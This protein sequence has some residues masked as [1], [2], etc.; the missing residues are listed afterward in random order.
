MDVRPY[1]RPCPVLT[2][3]SIGRAFSRVSQKIPSPTPFPKQSCRTFLGPVSPRATSALVDYGKGVD[4][5]G[6]KAKTHANPLLLLRNL[7]S[8]LFVWE[9][10][11]EVSFAPPQD[12]TKIICVKRR[13]FGPFPCL[14]FPFTPSSISLHFLCQG[15]VQSF[16]APPSPSSLPFFPLLSNFMHTNQPP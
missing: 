2:L 1:F 16:A 9:E 10:T 4:Y 8:R 12:K 13:S 15:Q 3:R 11:R 7:D 6:G 14:L 5:R